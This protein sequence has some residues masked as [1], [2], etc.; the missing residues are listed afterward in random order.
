MNN[1][2]YPN[3]GF[4]KNEALSMDETLKGMTFWNAFASFD[5]VGVELEKG[6]ELHL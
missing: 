3:G 1:K 4:L 6:R 5:G 2:D